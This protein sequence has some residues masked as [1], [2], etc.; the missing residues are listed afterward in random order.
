VKSPGISL[1]ERE[2]DAG[3]IES[4]KKVAGIL[5]TPKDHKC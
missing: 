5:K 4:K 1:E 2:A 3:S